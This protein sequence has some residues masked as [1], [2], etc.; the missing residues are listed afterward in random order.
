MGPLAVAARRRPAGRAGW[1]GWPSWPSPRRCRCVRLVARRA[2]ALDVVL[3]AVRLGT[4]AGTAPAYRR[5]GAAYWLSPTA[6]VAAVAALARGTFTRR[7]TWRGRTY[8]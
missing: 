6:D 2:D 1:P 8:R 7:Q 3:L 5:R 4:L